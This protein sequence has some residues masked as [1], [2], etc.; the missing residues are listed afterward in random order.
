MATRSCARCDRDRA[1][2]RQV[3]RARGHGLR[4]RCPPLPDTQPRLPLSTLS[5]SPSP[6]SIRCSKAL[7][8]PPACVPLPCSPM[9]TSAASCAHPTAQ[10][11]PCCRSTA[12]PAASSSRPRSPC[13]AVSR[14]R[15]MELP[16][17]QPA[18]GKTADAGVCL[19][20]WLL[21]SHEQSQQRMAQGLSTTHM[22]DLRSHT[23]AVR[24]IDSFIHPSN[25]P[26]AV[27][28]DKAIEMVLPHVAQV[29]WL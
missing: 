17:L 18:T 3:A 24:K 14:Q 5:H 10:R 7:H 12:A 21:E 9:P 26:H 6:C 23:R 1:P 27:T 22:L 20:R 15:R 2:H 11:W 13:C 25:A 4:V 28:R 19:H 16:A 8:P 29:R